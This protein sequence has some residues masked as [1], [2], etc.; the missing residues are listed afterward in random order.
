[1]A[2]IAVV[3]TQPSI[4]RPSIGLSRFASDTIRKRAA[5]RRTSRWC[6]RSSITRRHRK[7]RSRW[8]ASG[9][10]D[11][12]RHSIWFR[13]LMSCT[14]ART[15]SSSPT[16]VVTKS[17]GCMTN[18][19]QV[20]C[21]SSARGH[22]LCLP[23]H[24]AQATCTG[25]DLCATAERNA[26]ACRGV[27]ESVTLLDVCRIEIELIVRLALGTPSSSLRDRRAGSSCHAARPPNFTLQPSSQPRTVIQTPP[28]CMLT[29]D[30]SSSQP[31]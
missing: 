26:S 1:M 22:R 5:F 21:D 7:A 31:V 28:V 3:T 16:K 8:R 4:S 2:R 24:D 14:A 11:S 9:I 10:R 17:L 13:C 15:C 12:V 19:M 29:T 6:F 27:I 18:C 25:A 23:C 30:H 20:F